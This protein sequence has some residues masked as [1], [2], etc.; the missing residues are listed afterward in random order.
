MAIKNSRGFDGDAN[1]IRF[2]FFC[3]PGPGLHKSPAWSIKTDQEFEYGEE[4]RGA[5]F[6]FA[7][8]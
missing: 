3:R 8:G 6:V 4:R 1:G 7:S 5:E 2:D